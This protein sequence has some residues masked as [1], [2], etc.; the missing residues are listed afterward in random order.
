M[1]GSR[2]WASQYRLA[3]S[4]MP[5][6]LWAR[7]SRFAAGWRCTTINSAIVSAI[8]LSTDAGELGELGIPAGSGAE[9]HLERVGVVAHEVEVGAEPVLDLLV[10]TG[11]IAGRLGD[12]LAEV[13][14]DVGQELDEQLALR[15]EVLVEHRLGD[16]GG[17]GDV[18]HRRCVESVLGEHADRS[19][20]QLFSSLGSR[21]SHRPFH[22]NKW[23]KRR[24]HT[25]RPRIVS[26]RWI[27]RTTWCS[28]D[29]AVRPSTDRWPRT[30]SAVP[31]A[32]TPSCASRSHSR[33]SVT[34]APT[35]RSHRSA[36]R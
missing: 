27:W 24:P 8:E 2:S 17:L 6:M 7:S 19:A 23:S 34:S 31:A 5:T 13:S 28:P 1:S 30:R 33:G 25:G 29:C 12:R 20:Q 32:T 26:A 21:E 14:P 9:Q 35:S 10:G 22:G 16:P 3:A 11:G 36:V 15:A 4:V 18:V